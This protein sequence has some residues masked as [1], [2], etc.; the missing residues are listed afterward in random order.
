MCYFFHLRLERLDP[1]NLRDLPIYPLVLLRPFMLCWAAKRLN[2]T[3]AS[4]MNAPSSSIPPRCWDLDLD[5]YFFAVL[6]LFF[7]RP[8]IIGFIFFKAARS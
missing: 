4:L 6:L 7:L 1:L 8:P 2:G 3:A 5:L